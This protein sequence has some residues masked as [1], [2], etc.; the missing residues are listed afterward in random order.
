MLDSDLVASVVDELKSE[1]AARNA[2]VYVRALAGK[3]TVSGQVSCF[4]DKQRIDEAV[5]RIAGVD[6]LDTQISVKRFAFDAGALVL[7]ARS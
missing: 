2:R 4:T 1:P 3:V 6:G 5:R 7:P